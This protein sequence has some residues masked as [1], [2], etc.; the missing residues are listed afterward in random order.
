[1]SLTPGIEGVASTQSAIPG[2]WRKNNLISCSPAIEENTKNDGR[3]KK[4]NNNCGNK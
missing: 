4:N 1:M 3:Y 2:F